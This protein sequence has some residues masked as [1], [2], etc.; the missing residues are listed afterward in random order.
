M[1]LLHVCLINF[2]QES[3]L[4]PLQHFTW[5]NHDSF[6]LWETALKLFA[7]SH[8][9][10]HTSFLRNPSQRVCPYDQGELL[11]FTLHLCFIHLSFPST[12]KTTTTKHS[13]KRSDWSPSQ[14]HMPTNVAEPH[15]S[16]AGPHLKAQEPCWLICSSSSCSHPGE[17]LSRV[18]KEW[19]QFCGINTAVSDN[20]FGP[21]ATT[22]QRSTT[23]QHIL[24]LPRTTFTGPAHTELVLWM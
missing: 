23:E 18:W 4:V 7:T 22:E 11:M 14:W 12:G 21:G 24:V 8:E 3:E 10:K 19:R 16:C 6:A 2:S 17:T 1:S 15:M 20:L 9:I 5:C 13:I